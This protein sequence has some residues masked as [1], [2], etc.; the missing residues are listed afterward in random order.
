MVNFI[1]WAKT[2]YDRRLLLDLSRCIWESQKI[3]YQLCHPGKKSIP[4]AAIAIQTFGDF[5]GFNSKDNRQEKTSEALDWLATMTTHIPNH[6]E[7]M[8]HFPGYYNNLSLRLRQKERIGPT[9]TFS[10]NDTLIS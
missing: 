10:W 3:F 7:Q 4:G 8:V 5:L 1:S 2:S 9:F 6:E